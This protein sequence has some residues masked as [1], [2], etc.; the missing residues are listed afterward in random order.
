MA[1]YNSQLNSGTMNSFRHF[2]RAP[3]DKTIA[4]PLQTQDSHPLNGIQPHNV[5]V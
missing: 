3:G 4:R 1:Y 5:S 2:G